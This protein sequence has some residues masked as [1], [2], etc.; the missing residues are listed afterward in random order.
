MHVQCMSSPVSLALSPHVFF[1]CAPSP[2][3]ELF[4]SAGHHSQLAPVAVRAD[5]GRRLAGLD[6]LLTGSRVPH[7]RSLRETPF[8]HPF[9]PSWSLRV[10]AVSL[11][12]WGPPFISVFLEDSLVLGRREER[13]GMWVQRPVSGRSPRVSG[14]RDGLWAPAPSHPW[15]GQG[16]RGFA[17][18]VPGAQASSG[19]WELAALWAGVGACMAGAQPSPQAWRV[20][21]MFLPPQRLPGARWH[22]RRGQV[23]ELHGRRCGLR[24]PPAP[25]RP[26]PLPAPILRCEWVPPGPADP[27]GEGGRPDLSC[28]R[29]VG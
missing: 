28:D 23:P 14:R 26:A 20:K 11:P 5:P 4:F 18:G 13:G 21:H 12:T 9:L 8:A 27:G 24:G 15:G 16:V 2:G 25:G 3:E 6:L 7:V 1:T 17:V 22:R 19:G 29:E 10:P